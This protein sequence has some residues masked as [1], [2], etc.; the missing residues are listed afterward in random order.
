MYGPLAQRHPLLIDLPAEFNGVV[1]PF[2]GHT[3]G[4]LQQCL[5]LHQLRPVP[6]QFR[7]APTSSLAGIIL[8]IIGDS[9]YLLYANL[10]DLTRQT[11]RVS[12]SDRTHARRVGACAAGLGCSLYGTVAAS[13]D[14]GRQGA[15]TPER[16]RRPRHVVT[17]GR[18]AALPPRLPADQ[19]APTSAR[20]AM[21]SEPTPAPRVDS[22]LAPRLATR[23]SDARGGAGA[24]REPGRPQPPGAGGSPRWRPGRP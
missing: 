10:C 14:L 6:G 3:F 21:C 5:D 2:S 23:L 9:V 19:S 13:Q 15:P 8:D 16:R 1:P 4:P 18:Q 17:D 12:G 24:R 22:S 7:E 20:L 11:A